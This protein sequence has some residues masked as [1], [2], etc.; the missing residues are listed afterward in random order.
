[1]SWW[2]CGVALSRSL[3]RKSRA[4]SATCHIR[5]SQA[6]RQ[7]DKND[8]CHCF[9]CGVLPARTTITT[10]TTRTSRLKHAIYYPTSRVP[11]VLLPV[12]V[13]FKRLLFIE[14]SYFEPSVSFFFFFRPSDLKYTHGFF[15]CGFA[16]LFFEPEPLSLFLERFLNDTFCFKLI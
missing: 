10:T 1:M 11:V 13:I 3:A 2:R 16:D 8:A 4:E 5:S 6:T 14:P 12:Y 7:L 15:P 9:Y